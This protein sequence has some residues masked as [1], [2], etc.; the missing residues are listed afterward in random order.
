MSLCCSVVHAV[1][2][3]SGLLLSFST[4]AGLSPGTQSRAL[5]LCLQVKERVTVSSGATLSISRWRSI[6]AGWQPPPSRPLGLHHAH[7]G[8]TGESWGRRYCCQ[9]TFV[10]CRIPMKVSTS[11][12]QHS[13][14]SLPP[15]W[16][17]SPG[18]RPRHQD[19]MLMS[20]TVQALD[21]AGPDFKSCLRLSSPRATFDHFG[22]QPPICSWSKRYEGKDRVTLAASEDRGE[23]PVK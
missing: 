20:S 8:V 2:W 21:L 11:C 9:R 17:L 16:V 3:E 23:D 15:N 18:V 12:S 7:R 13:P 10:K 14:T 1:S 22:P 19:Q 6:L 5:H 4:S